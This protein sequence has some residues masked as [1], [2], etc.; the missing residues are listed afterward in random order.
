MPSLTIL[1]LSLQQFEKVV[2]SPGGG[3]ASRGREYLDIAEAIAVGIDR[4]VGGAP[5]SSIDRAS[6][7]I[8]LAATSA[9]LWGEHRS[10][11]HSWAGRRTGI[12][13]GSYNRRKG[14]R[15]QA[16]SSSGH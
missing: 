4:A 8:G 6:S 11:R 7:T 13:A 14:P 3:S 15:T 5:G 12:R 9:Q 1:P 2:L 10:R 16:I